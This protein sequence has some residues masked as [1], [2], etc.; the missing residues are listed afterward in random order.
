MEIQ[1]EMHP[2]Q[3]AME[4]ERSCDTRWSS[5]SGSVHKI[6]QLLDVLLEALAGFPE[7]SGQNENK[8]RAAPAADATCD[9]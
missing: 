4:L 9:F 6:L 3:Q 5:K 7:T 2:N 1:K 8:S